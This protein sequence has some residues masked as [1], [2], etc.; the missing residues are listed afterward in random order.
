MVVGAI[1]AA[2]PVFEAVI[3]GVAAERSDSGARTEVTWELGWELT[4]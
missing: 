2:A 3:H 1:D 4:S